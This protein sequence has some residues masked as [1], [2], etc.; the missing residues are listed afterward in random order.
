MD[1]MDHSRHELLILKIDQVE[2]IMV[3][4]PQKIDQ[5]ST[6]GQLFCQ[7]ALL[8]SK[9][10]LCSHSNLFKKPLNITR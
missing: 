1:I 10:I 6:L 2:Q 4:P 3:E 8:L 9:N 7:L 5:K